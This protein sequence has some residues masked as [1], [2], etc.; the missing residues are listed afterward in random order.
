MGS[1]CTVIG[2]LPRISLESHLQHGRY[3]DNTRPRIL[4]HTRWGA[5]SALGPDGHGAVDLRVLPN[6][7]EPYALRTERSLR[8]SHPPP[9]SSARP[10]TRSPPPPAAPSSS[11]LPSSAVPLP[12]HPSPSA[13]QIEKLSVSHHTCS[14]SGPS[15]PSLEHLAVLLAGRSSERRLRPV[16]PPSSTPPRQTKPDS[17]QL[18]LFLTRLSSCSPTV[19]KAFEKGRPQD[20]LQPGL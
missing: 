20:S 11:S 16:S 15:F 8:S 9:A 3:T 14:P 5:R 4:A 17:S 13:P 2:F 7:R 18:S 6:H 1:S 10:Y 19:R 12:V